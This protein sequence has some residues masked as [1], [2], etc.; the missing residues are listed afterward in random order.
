MIGVRRL[1]YLLLPLGV[2][3]ISSCAPLGA[4]PGQIAITSDPPGADV[5]A[6]G[7]RVGA[8]PISLGKEAV[9]P[10][11]YP[12]EQ[13]A[14]FG[15]VELRKPGCSGS[16]QRVSLAAVARGVHVKLD[17]G[18]A[19][20]GAEPVARQAQARQSPRAAVEAGPKPA[21][22]HSA[23]VE[24]RLRHVQELRD[25]GVITEQ[26]ARET[27]QRILGEL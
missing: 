17:C 16:V 14:L 2:A 3:L 8:T 24:A 1:P 9:F 27:R 20:S 23:S 12:S 7:Q 26:E 5:Y 19:A 18:E 11:T 21:P 10:A 13:Q 15:S 4:K 25:K 22:K 6:M